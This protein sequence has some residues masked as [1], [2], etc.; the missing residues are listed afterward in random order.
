MTTVTLGDLL[1]AATDYL[2][3]ATRHSYQQREPGHLGPAISETARAADALQ[4]HLAEIVADSGIQPY[5]SADST[6]IY[7]AIH[8]QEALR[9]A[10]EHLTAAG[11]AIKPLRTPPDRDPL[12][13]DNLSRDWRA[14][15]SIQVGPLTLDQAPV[16]GQQRRRGHDAVQSQVPGQQSRRG[17]EYGPV[18]PVR[19]RAGDL[20]PQY[21]DFMAE[22][23]DLRVPGG[24]A[25]CQERQPAEH[26]DHERVD[27]TDQHERR[28]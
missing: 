1:V 4:R 19:P 16:P 18:S 2:A 14:S 6:A 24:V 12:T 3:A 15:R 27:E 5:M 22:H 8:A 28:A 13:P 9:E 25:A 20:T 11:N 17:G 23:Q 21:R 7:L 26:A 10:A